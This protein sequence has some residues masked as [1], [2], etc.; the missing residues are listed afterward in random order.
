MATIKMPDNQSFELDDT[1]AGDDAQLRAALSAAYPDAANATFERT[2]GND[3]KPLTVRVIKKAG[4]KGLGE[5][6]DDEEWRDVIGFE[7]VYSVSNLGRVRRDLN[8]RGV[9]QDKRILKLAIKKDGY[10]DVTLSRPGLRKHVKVHKLVAAAF[11]GNAAGRT[12]NHKDGNKSNNCLENLEYL[13]QSENVRHAFQTGLKIPARGIRSGRY[14]KPE[15]TAR[16]EKHG[17]AKLKDAD[18]PRIF[19]MRKSGLLLR[20]IGDRLGVTKNCISLILKGKSRV[21]KEPEL[22]A[23]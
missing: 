15:K 7:G 20:E 3:G 8:S 23:K 9:F 6:P 14:T 18:I 12:V 1:I 2:G 19:E 17:N 22:C 21:M 11:L 5:S 4:T 16:G 13:T 10:L